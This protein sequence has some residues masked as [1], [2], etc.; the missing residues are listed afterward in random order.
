MTPEYASPEQLLGAPVTTATDVYSLGV[1]LFELL[2]GAKP[3]D[4]ETRTPTTEAPRAEHARRARCAA[5]STRSSRA[6][7]KS[8]PRGATARSRSFA[9][10]VRRHLSGHPV[11]ARPRDVRLSRVEVRAPQQARRRRGRGDRRS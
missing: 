7:W 5:I 10:D 9:D 1:L 8:I 11:A 2:T 6:R 3:F 4:A